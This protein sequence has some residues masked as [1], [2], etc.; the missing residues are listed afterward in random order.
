M[1]IA[2]IS[3][4]LWHINVRNVKLKEDLDNSRQ[5]YDLH[6]AKN[7]DYIERNREKLV[8]ETTANELLITANNLATLIVT[9]RKIC[10]FE[11]STNDAEKSREEFEQEH[12]QGAR[13]LFFGNLSHSGVPV[14]PLQLQRYVR[15]LGVDSDCRVV[16]YDKGQQIWA[17]YA[18]WLFRLFGHEKTSLLN[19]GFLEYKAKAKDQSNLYKIVEG[20]ET[21]IKRLGKFK[22]RW[23][24]VIVFAS[25][26]N[27]LGG[28]FHCNFRRCDS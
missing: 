14:H 8:N 23:V 27:N 2:L 21:A 10:I 22:A 24:S 7:N 17:T 13:L 25:E 4:F 28:R 18:F 1:I 3:A 6:S 15:N 12:I 9:K 16:L 20:P 19:G 11:V 5:I 26:K